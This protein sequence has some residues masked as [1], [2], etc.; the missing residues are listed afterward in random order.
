MKEDLLANVKI[1]K[2][3]AQE[4]VAQ[5]V[6]EN[7][8]MQRR[9]YDLLKENTEWKLENERLNN[10]I[11]KFNKLLIEHIEEARYELNIILHSDNDLDYK[12]ECA[13]EFDI[14]DKNIR[15]ILDK[16]KELKG[17]DNEKD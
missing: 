17:E 14:L 13:R 6:V 3:N 8:N 5:L 7:A 1:T 2:E 10:I 16:L 9:I 11:N 12:N 4:I 15:M